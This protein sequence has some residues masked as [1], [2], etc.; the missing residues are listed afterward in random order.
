MAGSARDQTDPG[1]KKIATDPR[2]SSK[3]S[4]QAVVTRLQLQNWR[5]FLSVDVKLARRVFVIGPNASGKSNLLDA[6]RFLSDI[7][8]IG[9]GLQEAVR[10]RRGVSSLRCLAARQYS[11]ISLIATLQPPDQS[12]P[13]TY[14]LAIGQD[15]QRR[16][17]IKHEIVKKGLRTILNRPD[18]DDN[19]DHERLTQ[20]FLEQVNA[21]G[22]FRAI[23]SILRSLKYLHIVPQLIREPDRSIGRRNDP[24]GG[25]FIEQMARTPKATRDARLRRIGDAL[26]V[27]V[28]QLKELDLEQDERGFWHLRGKYKHWRP[29]GAWQ[30]EA[31]FSDGTLRLLGLL[32]A[33]L[34][35]TGPVL[36][37][38]PELSLHPEVVRHLP[39]L[40]A[41][42]QRRV[43]RQIITST[44]SSD[45]LQ[46]PGIGLDEILI[47]EP[48][49][50]GTAVKRAKDYPDI[51]E[52]LMGGVSLAD[53]VLPRTRPSEARQ[54]SLFG[55]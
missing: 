54:L 27:A 55:G 36:L 48:T 39:Q 35:G 18:K 42:V 22:S 52:L 46:D 12:E 41:S 5:N 24:F 33:T 20:T 50:E 23:A 25:D 17:I 16:A 8:S 31:E 2:A 30:S 3:T 45:L 26:Q 19:N 53:A 51:Y 9:G 4:H 44:H 10:R 7:A 47:L 11:D 13:W 43:P 14:T 37:E 1:S 15:K 28:P 21:N 49:S 34:D 40:F 6:L 32:W 38:E 29:K